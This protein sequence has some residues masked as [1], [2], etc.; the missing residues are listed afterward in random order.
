MDDARHRQYTGVGNR[1]ILENLKVLASLGPALIVRVPLMPGINDDAE[2][3]R[4]T[5]AFVCDLATVRRVDL[6]PFHPIADGKYRRLK[7]DNQMA[8]TRSPNRQECQAYSG[9][10]AQCGLAVTVG[11]ET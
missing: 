4:R 9:L 7:R 2:I 6:L 3:L 1:R 10:F 11:G 5:A 8:G